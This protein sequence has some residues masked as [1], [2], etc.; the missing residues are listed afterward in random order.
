MKHLDKKEVNVERS[1][2]GGNKILCSIREGEFLYLMKFSTKKT[3][4][5]Y[6]DM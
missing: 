2:E 3:L 1:C 5:I 4:H 6:F